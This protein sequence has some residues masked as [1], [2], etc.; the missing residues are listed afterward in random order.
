MMN[1]ELHADLGR[2]SVVVL[3]KEE[4]AHRWQMTTSQWPIMHAVIFGVS[5]DQMMA[6]HKVIHLNIAYT[7]PVDEA[8]KALAATAAC[9]HQQGIEVHLCG[10]SF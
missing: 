3:P 8:D 6:R 5:R 1:G 4:T 10:V 2:A 7:P 9:L